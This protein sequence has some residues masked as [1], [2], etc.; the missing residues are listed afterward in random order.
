MAI[1]KELN[2]YLDRLEKYLK[3]MPID[4]RTD[5]IQEIKGEMV[6]LQNSGCEVNEITERFGSPKDLAKCYLGE[7]LSK[8]TAI[9]W[10]KI[11]MA[12][13]FYCLAGFS[14]MFI[15][16]VTGIAG[17]TFLICGILCP[18]A[19]IIKFVAHIT[20][21]EI[22]EIVFNIGNFNANAIQL[23]P[24]S[25]LMGVLC[26]SAGWLLWKLTIK[27]IKSMNHARIKLNS[28]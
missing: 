12:A 21:H 11:M 20:G 15:L 27:I 28:N 4:E 2:E 14:G 17:I 19:G 7:S 16:P 25:I 10:R 5:I 3:S 18:A 1:N 6:E 24:I 13:A 8:S 9:S 22:E 23:L 26:L